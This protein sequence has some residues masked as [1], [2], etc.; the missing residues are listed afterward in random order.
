MA[1]AKMIFHVFPPSMNRNAGLQGK[2][3]QKKAVSK[4]FE[5]VNHSGSACTDKN[6]MTTACFFEKRLNVM[7]SSFPLRKGTMDGTKFIKAV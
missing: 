3:P 4:T 1:T 5:T 2:F 7:T 6:F